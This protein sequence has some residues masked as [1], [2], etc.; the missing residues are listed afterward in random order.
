MKKAIFTNPVTGK[1]QQVNSDG[2]KSLGFD[3][4]GKL[5]YQ[6]FILGD[7]F[8]MRGFLPDAKHFV[9]F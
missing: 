2:L 3:E 1:K 4:N 9:K 8:N 7:V 5:V 6:E